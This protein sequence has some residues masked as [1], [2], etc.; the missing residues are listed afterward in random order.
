MARKPDLERLEQIYQAIKEHPGKKAGY[1][2]LILGLH[3]S[4]VTRALP[5]LDKNGMYICE[6]E[7]GRLWIIVQNPKKQ[8]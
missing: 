6:D 7:Q 4:D 1:I 5:N 3:R 2:A 8:E